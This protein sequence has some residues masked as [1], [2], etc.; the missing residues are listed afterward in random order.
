MA[1]I[2]EFKVPQQSETDR[3]VAADADA[4]CHAETAQII[5]FPGIRMERYDVDPFLEEDGPFNHDE[6]QSSRG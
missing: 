1:T 3:D 6:P 2:L 5:F 4:S